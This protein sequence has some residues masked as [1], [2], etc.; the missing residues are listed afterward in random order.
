MPADCW[1]VLLEQ[2]WL[3]QG[4]T[5]IPVSPLLDQPTWVRPQYNSSLTGTPHMHTP[6]ENLCK[7]RR[8][9]GSPLRVSSPLP[10]QDPL[11]S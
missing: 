1:N 11:P 4:L 9:K 10:V 6:E 3:H 5:H 2:H 8:Q 7:T